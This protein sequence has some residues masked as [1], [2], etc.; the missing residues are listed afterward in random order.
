MA[1]NR[2]PI[3]G[4]T[5]KDPPRQCRL[6][7]QVMDGTVATPT[8][9]T[10]TMTRPV[11]TKKKG[12]GSF[13]LIGV[14][15][16]LVIAVLAILLGFT[17][18]DLSASRLRDR[19]PFLRTTDDGWV[20]VDDADGGFTVEMPSNRQQGS[21]PFPSAENGRLVGWTA[22]IGTDTSL[23]VYFA[24]LVPVDGETAKGTV[25]RMVDEA[26]F[27]T[28]IVSAQHNHDTQV[29]KRTDTDFRGYPAVVYELSGVDINGDYGYQKAIIFVKGETIY[30]LASNSIYK[31]H[32]QWDRFTS[33]FQ[34]TA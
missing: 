6:C 34:F 18:G 33:S 2:C 22:T 17:S 4:A 19:V 8:S 9:T 12:V 13:V 14:A 20:Q 21:T 32:P 27:Q 24:P 7:G 31:D 28:E 23:A 3:C 11:A 26:I 15:A 30:T 5:H 25:N 1:K 29:I 10:A 16:V